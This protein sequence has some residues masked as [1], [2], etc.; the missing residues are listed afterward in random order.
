MLGALWLILQPLAMIAVYTVIFSQVMGSRMPGVSSIFGYSIYL[1]A[2]MIT[3]GLFSEIV[4]RSQN[5][6]V[7]NANLLKKLSFPRV[8]LPSIVVLSAVMNFVIIFSLFSV[9][10]IFTNNF[11]GIVFIALIPLLLVQIIFSV[12]LGITLGV[13]N[14]FFRDVGQFMTI[15]MQFWFWFTPVV[16]PW[17]I[18]PPSVARIVELNPM[19]NLVRGYQTILVNGQLPNW[20]TIWPTLLLSLLLCALGLYLFRRHSGEMVDEL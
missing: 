15:F 11:P 6:F 13:L 1:C 12:G 17:S 16:Y 10:L 3:W 9:F 8:A 5:V 19:A 14:V 20:A 7:D 4:V 2:G 18:L